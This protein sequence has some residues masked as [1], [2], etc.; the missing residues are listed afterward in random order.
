[1][2]NGKAVLTWTTPTEGLHGGT[3]DPDELT[4]TIVRYPGANLV[5]QG[6]HGNRFT[7]TLPADIANYYYTV[8][9]CLN[10]EE[11]G[12]ST[13][14]SFFAGETFTV[15]YI[16]TFDDA[17]GFNGYTAIDG[18]GDGYTWEFKSQ[19]QAVSTRF[20]STEQMN[21][22]LITPPIKF[23]PNATYQLTFKA[24]AF[25]T[26][27]PER[28][29]VK[30]GGAP[31]PEAMTQTLLSVVQTNNTNYDTYSASFKTDAEG[32][33]YIGFRCTSYANS[34]RLIVDDIE[35]K[36]TEANAVPSA[37]TDL[38]AES[39]SDGTNN[40][41]ISFTAPTTLA[42]GSKL[43][44]LTSIKIFRGTNNA[45]IK[46]FDKPAPGSKL[47]YKDEDAAMGEQTYRVIAY[48]GAG[49]GL[50]ASVKAYAG[51]DVP[52][53]PQN[54]RLVFDE[55]KNAHLTWEAPTQGVN[56]GALNPAALFYEIVRND[57]VTLKET[58]QGL[59]YTDYSLQGEAEQSMVYYQITTIHGT[60]RGEHALSSFVII[61]DDQPIPFTESFAA[62]SL[63]NTPWTISRVTGHS[64]MCWSL[65]GS[66]TAPEAAPQDGDSGFASFISAGKESGIIERMTS[67]KMDLFS[68]QHPVMSFY[69]YNTTAD[70]SE[71]LA[72]QIT[73]ND[74]EFTTLREIP[75][76]GT[77]EGWNLYEIEIP[78]KDCLPATSIAFLATTGGEMNIHLDH[79][80][81]A[82]GDVELEECDLEAVSLEV[83]SLVPDTEA[84]IILNVYN[85]GSKAVES[86]NVAL[87]VDGAVAIT[88]KSTEPIE[89][90][91]TYQY[92][93][94]VT[95][96]KSDLNKKFRF[97]GTVSCAGDTNLD[98]NETDEVEA[99]VGVTAIDSIELDDN[100][101][102]N[103]YTLDGVVV[104]KNVTKSA[105]QDL[106]AGIYVVK[107][108]NGATYK[109]AV[110]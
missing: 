84:K 43:N 46:T 56:G 22:W 58:H 110:H 60:T 78:R 74:G 54:V 81:V 16:Q 101:L 94:T 20:N 61:G 92:I 72:V 93:F 102:V 86:Y 77:K 17:D 37:V 39:A 98:N 31:Q 5:A 79:I 47:S 3:F 70:C 26:D 23:A 55:D 103:V 96:E 19:W 66:G 1:M 10:D 107:T 48:N 76:K 38:K 24:R 59:S 90:G 2:A 104:L 30:L 91:D 64:Q 57:G 85:N 8:T 71:K 52:R 109:V 42:D 49:A 53:A 41:I 108:E 73:H 97:K 7:E 105:L 29:E 11:G 68:A 32:V 87:L 27:S 95:P 33:L 69:M 65:T 62:A 21:D 75:L 89:A 15:P 9:A 36:L 100:T 63:E 67:P 28:F 14:N 6:F 4:Y 80:M 50:E 99:I 35:V 25:D 40:V 18:D 106:D 13:S 45:P 12:T 44:D 83:P 82:N 88:A 34:Y 51:Y